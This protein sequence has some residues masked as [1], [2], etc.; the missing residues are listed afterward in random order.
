MPRK[1]KLQV[2]VG[3]VQGELYKAVQRRVKFLKRKQELEADKDRETASH[4]ESINVIKKEIQS[5]DKE[6]KAL[7]IVMNEK[8]SKLEQISS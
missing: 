1:S 6:L 3:K 7:D 5:I 4:K 2:D 8:V